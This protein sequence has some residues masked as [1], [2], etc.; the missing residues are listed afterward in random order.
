LPK[1]YRPVR[2]IYFDAAVSVR[3]ERMVDREDSDMAI[4]SRLHN[5]DTPDDWYGNLDKLV[6]HYKNLE[7]IDIELYKIN[8]NENMENVIEQILYYI[9]KNNNE[10]E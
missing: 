2:I 3:I 4:I 10:V 9:N 6:W 8:A 7:N 5:D 1:S